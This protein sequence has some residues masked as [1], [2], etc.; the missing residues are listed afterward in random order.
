MVSCRDDASDIGWEQ[1][2]TTF[3]SS[4]Q[5]MVYQG[6]TATLAVTCQHLYITDFVSSAM[7]AG[8]NMNHAR[9]TCQ[10]ISMK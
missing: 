7:L 2:G 3:R 6:A 8:D 5:E 10:C 9:Y 4:D 1:I